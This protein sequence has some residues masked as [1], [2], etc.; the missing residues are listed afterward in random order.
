M[1]EDVE[2]NGQCIAVNGHHRLAAARRAGREVRYEVEP[3]S[4]LVGRGS[5]VRSMSTLRDAASVGPDRI[6]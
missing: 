3:R 5:G 2:R 6:R 1:I 4:S